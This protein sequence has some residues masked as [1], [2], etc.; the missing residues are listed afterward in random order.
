MAKGSVATDFWKIGRALGF[1]VCALDHRR[2]R[3]RAL[4]RRR[5]RLKV[6]GASYGHKNI[7]WTG[8]YVGTPDVEDVREE[9]RRCGVPGYT[10]GPACHACGQPLPVT[11]DPVRGE[12]SS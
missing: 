8:H 5:V 4:D 11:G 9:Y 12:A 2:T 10:G 6:I 7:M 1:S 3:G